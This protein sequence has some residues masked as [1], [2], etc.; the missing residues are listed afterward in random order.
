LQQFSGRFESAL[1][2]SPPFPAGVTRGSIYFRMDFAK[3]MDAWVKPA[4]DD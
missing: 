4:H 2:R 3:T 1:A